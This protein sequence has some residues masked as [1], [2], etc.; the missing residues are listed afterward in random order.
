MIA[1]WTS[2]QFA[3][4]ATAQSVGKCAGEFAE[5]QSALEKLNSN[6]TAL[7][8]RKSDPIESKIEQA[9]KDRK[10]EQSTAVIVQAIVRDRNA[11]VSEA[12][13]ECARLAQIEQMVFE[14]WKR[15]RNFETGARTPL[16][17]DA[18][19]VRD[20]SARLSR[21]EDLLLDDA[22]LQYKKEAP[23]PTSYSGN[24]TGGRGMSYNPYGDNSGPNGGGGV[25]R[26]PNA[27]PRRVGSESYAPGV[28]L[29]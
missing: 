14:R 20:R 12:G 11:A 16:G 25:N 17:Q 18:A 7:A 26:Q 10:P 2:V 6:M 4:Q 8:E 22:F 13:N 29:Q 15:C 5:W 1:V 28:G 3:S 21:L 9:L 24:S 23:N 27:G 19:I